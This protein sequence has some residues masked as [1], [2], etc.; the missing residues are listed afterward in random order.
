L[1]VVLAQK[2]KISLLEAVMGAEEVAVVQI[3]FNN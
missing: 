2:I 3:K 1:I